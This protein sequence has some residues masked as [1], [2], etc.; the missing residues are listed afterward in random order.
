MSARLPSALA[1]LALVA[2]R[3]GG[4]AP[5]APVIAPT[6]LAATHTPPP[7]Y[8][9]ALACAN[10]G[11]TVLL[12]VTVSQTG[13]PSALRLLDSSGNEQL[14]QLA[15]ARVREWEFKAATRNGQPVSQTFQVPVTFTPPLERPS[16]CFALDAGRN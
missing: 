9:L 11:G 7:D 4:D 13:N 14:D 12:Q 15:Q 6:E 8:P 3:G 2:C 16:E 5:A 1:L 10:I